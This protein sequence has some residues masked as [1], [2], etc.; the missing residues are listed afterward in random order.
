MAEED[1]LSFRDTATV[2]IWIARLPAF[3]TGRTS[4]ISEHTWNQGMGGSTMRDWV[5]SMRR[6]PGRLSPMP[7]GFGA[8]TL[9]GFGRGKSISTMSTLQNRKNGFI[10]RV[11]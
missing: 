3:Q 4:A 5:G 2:R 8:N 9:A 7:P 6:T 1:D 11:I 10:G